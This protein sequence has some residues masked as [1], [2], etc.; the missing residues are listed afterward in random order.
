VLQNLPTILQDATS[1]LDLLQHSMKEALAFKV[2]NPEELL[3]TLNDRYLLGETQ[4]EAV[5]WAWPQE[6]GGS[7]FHLVQT[8]TK[9]SQFETLSVQ[10]RYQLQVVGSEVLHM[11]NS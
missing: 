5:T 9:A 6:K 8:Y 10:E 4:R 3:M 11:A 7:K 2:D 1:N